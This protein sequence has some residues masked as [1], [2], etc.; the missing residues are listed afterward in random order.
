MPRASDAQAAARREQVEQLWVRGASMTRI[1]KTLGC[2]WQTVKR[3]LTIIGRT[4]A[5]EVDA[6]RELRR[7]LRAAQ[8]V[9]V[10]AWGDAQ[11]GLVLASLKT[12]VAVLAALQGLDVVARLELLEQRLDALTG[13]AGG[14][15][16]VGLN[17]YA[18]GRGDVP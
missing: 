14:L 5:E 6:P 9:E 8:A 4:L 17:G 13:A 11:P 18:N 2:D 12:Q 1:G 15:H 16:G 7:L 3:D 10:A